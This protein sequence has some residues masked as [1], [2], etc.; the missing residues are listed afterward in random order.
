MFPNLSALLA[1]FLVGLLVFFPWRANAVPL[2]PA[3][4]QTAAQEPITVEMLQ[5]SVPVALRDVWL[6]AEAE[7][8]KPWLEQQSG[9]LGRDIYWDP[10]Q[11]QAQLL[12]RWRSQQEWKAI[13][14]EE[15][16]VVQSRFMKAINKATSKDSLDPIPMIATSQWLLLVRDMPQDA[17]PERRP[18]A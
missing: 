13:P 14:D 8:W 17:S 7:V 6:N 16:A 1:C 2:T 15:V 5:L 10:Q 3:T 18:S 12:I 11:Q 9:Y 4:S